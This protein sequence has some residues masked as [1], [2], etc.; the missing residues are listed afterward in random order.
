MSNAKS[1]HLFGTDGIRGT[2]GEYPLDRISILKLGNAV[3]RVLPGL[4]IIIGR[5]TRQSSETIMRLL[6]S[7]ISA[8]SAK[9]ISYDCGVIPTPGLSFITDHDDFDFG[10]MITASH[11][12]WSDNGIKIFQSNGE[13]IPLVLERKLE[14]VFANIQEPMEVEGALAPICTLSRGIYRNFL[15]DVAAQLENT[16]IKEFKIVLD[17]AN[18]AVF[19]EAPAIFKQAGF[20]PRV[21]NNIPN[22]KNI[23]RGCGS[24]DIDMLK[25]QVKEDRAD[26]GIAFDG[27]GDRVIMV[28]PGGNILDGDH[29]LYLIAQYFLETNHDFNKIVVGTVQG[30]LG[31]EKALNK[32]GIQYTRTQVGDKY[33]YEEMKKQQSILGGEQSGHTIL[34]SFQR[35]GDGILAALF[36]LKALFHFQLTPGEVFQKLHLYPQTTRNIPIREKPDLKQWDELNGMIREFEKRHGLNSRVLIRYSGTEPL[37]RVM[38]ESEEQSVIHE[39]MEKFVHFIT[40]TIGK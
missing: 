13:K 35:T 18:G 14:E 25:R 39:Y 33:V 6:S 17:C 20:S 10:I 15:I 3:G 34:S 19:E 37:I 11:N 12:P 16:N 26:L 40:S 30:N 2:F 27:D 38:L 4:K 21:I 5:D 36:F 24:T 32:I 1:N 23:N 29:I 31:L 9:I 22:G 8:M 28:E 7:G